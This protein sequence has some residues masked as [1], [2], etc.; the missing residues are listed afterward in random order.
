MRLTVKYLKNLNCEKYFM[1]K[2]LPIKY[3]L[4]FDRLAYFIHE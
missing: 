4:Y 3:S 1:D 2:D